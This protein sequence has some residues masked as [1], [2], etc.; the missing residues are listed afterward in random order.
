MKSKISLLIFIFLIL[1]INSFACTEKY[2]YQG[3]NVQ[4]CSEILKPE[5]DIN[6]DNEQVYL[7][8]FYLMRPGT[9]TKID[10]N[11]VP[12]ENSSD[13]FITSFPSLSMKPL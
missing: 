6:F 9:G 8:K 5:I 13:S 1:V 3:K 12:S 7:D 4:L 11:S 2:D 10:L